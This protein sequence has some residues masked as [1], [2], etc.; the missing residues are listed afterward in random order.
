MLAPVSDIAWAAGLF[1]GEGCLTITGGKA[2]TVQAILATNDEDV[3]N[4]FRRIVGFG[5]IYKYEQ[6]RE[7]RWVAG[8]HETV[9]ALIAAFWPWLGSRRQTR[10]KT[11][12]AFVHRL[13]P[14]PNRR[15][16]HA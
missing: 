1:E 5:K 7:F 16:M 11:I 10:A 15:Q 3:I 13:R 9:Q 4:R 12:L 8:R 14:S 2:P 6:D